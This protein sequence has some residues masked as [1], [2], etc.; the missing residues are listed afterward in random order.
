M[1]AMASP[2][3]AP[4]WIREVEIES[5]RGIPRLSFSLPQGDPATGQWIVLLGDNGTGKTSLLRALALAMATPQVTSG[6][7]AQSLSAMVRHGARGASVRVRGDHV[8]GA[9]LDLLPK[10]D[11]EGV[12]NHAPAEVPIHAFGSLRGGA[13]GGAK[14]EVRLDAFSAISTLFDPSASLIHAD[15][16][17]RD[18]AYA[19]SLDKQ[20]DG[21]TRFDRV[22]KTIVSLL[23]GVDDIDVRSDRTWVRGPAVGEVPLASLSDG[24]LTTLGWTIDLLARWTERLKEPGMTWERAARCVV[25]VDELDLHLH[26]RWQTE[27]VSR[28]RDAF[29]QT[30]FVVTTHNPLTL[31]GTRPGEVHVLRRTDDGNVEILQ[32]D[33]PLGVTAD[34][35]LTGDW[36]GLPSTLDLDTQA[37]IARHTEMLRAQVPEA[38]PRRLELEEELR[39]RLGRFAET[40]IE[41]LAQSVVAELLDTGKPIT[42]ADRARIKAVVEARLR[43]TPDGSSRAREPDPPPMKRAP[44][45]KPRPKAKSAS[46]KKAGV[47]S[48]A[49][50]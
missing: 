15:T 13:L 28:L 43:R 12:F 42:D 17:L 40:S 23:P 26:P 32:R 38:A 46:R 41:R 34:Q 19:A 45:T 14:R 10:R 9:A 20:G 50:S 37:L 49:R 4:V 18:L 5:F 36:F 7:L 35:V 31:H 11:I 29:P 27:V 25:L 3:S 22:R 24:Y 16:W 21:R 8:V 39:L 1:A 2:A 33:L 6:V 48:K 47:R 44:A 30:T